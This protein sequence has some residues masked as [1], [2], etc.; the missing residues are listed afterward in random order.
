[1]LAYYWYRGCAYSH[2]YLGK[3]HTANLPLEN[4]HHQ[5]FNMHPITTE[6]LL[7]PQYALH[8]RPYSSTKMETS[9]MEMALIP[10]PTP[11]APP[12]QHAPNVCIPY[13]ILTII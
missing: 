4:L 1:M 12:A 10:A 13:D 5:A 7:L 8:D 9:P 3:P 2:T 11:P 6:Y